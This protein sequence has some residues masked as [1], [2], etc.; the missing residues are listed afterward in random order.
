MS[1]FVAGSEEENNLNQDE[2][3][4]TAD[5]TDIFKDYSNKE[6]HDLIDQTK[7]EFDKVDTENR[8]FLSYIG[9]EDPNL[10]LQ[11]ATGMQKLPQDIYDLAVSNNTFDS[12]S[13]MDGSS[14][15]ESIYSRKSKKS[16]S[17]FSRGSQKSMQTG[18][19][20]A[21]GYQ[22]TLEQLSPLM[23]IEMA[24]KAIKEKTE[25]IKKILNES[26]GKIHQLTC[27]AKEIQAT[28]SEIQQKKLKFQKEILL[29]GIDP[30]TGRIPSETFLKFI[31]SKIKQDSTLLDK[32]RLRTSSLKQTAKTANSKLATKKQL[33]GILRPVDFEQLKIDKNTLTKLLKEKDSQFYGLK[34]VNGQISLACA[35]QKKALDKKLARVEELKARKTL[36][37][38]S[39]ERLCREKSVLKQKIDEVR[40]EIGKLEYKME[41]YSTP[42]VTDYCNQKEKLMELERMNKK[43]RRETKNRRSKENALN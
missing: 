39:I 24:E 8:M 43:L 42:S 2:S 18:T 4:L 13:W 28:I 23:K 12:T 36:L 35:T 26:S 22:K 9:F 10:A 37:F 20:E 15:I 25:N 30:I 21:S 1:N 19:S 31:R 40:E 34:Q 3:K 5:E 29:E 6:L 38:K 33:V 17:I 32:L 11:V 16:L 7:T 41:H 27:E 14:I